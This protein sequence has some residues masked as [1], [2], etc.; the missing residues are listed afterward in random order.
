MLRLPFDENGTK[1]PVVLGKENFSFSMDEAWPV[2]RREV[3]W[4]E[5][6][7][8]NYPYFLSVYLLKSELLNA[9]IDFFFSFVEELSSPLFRKRLLLSA[10]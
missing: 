10:N 2:V 7:V 9:T 8:L 6:T 1:V 4:P 3:S 5:E